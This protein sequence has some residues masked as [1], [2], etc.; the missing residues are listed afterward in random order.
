MNIPIPAT[1][2]R[3][4]SSNGL[5]ITRDAGGRIAT[6]TMAP[7]KTVTYTYDNRDNLT[8]VA[9]W[10]GDVTT[11]AYDDAGRLIEIT[12]PNGIKTNYTYD[13]ENRVTSITEGSI[14][15]IT[16]TRDGNGQI[17]S[18]ARNLP[19]SVSQNYTYTY[20]KAGRLTS[21]SMRNYTWDLASRLTSFTEGTN[22]TTFTYDSASQISTYT[23]DS[24]GRLTNDDTHSYTWDL[25]SRLTSYTEGFDATI[26]ACFGNPG[27]KEAREV[28][29]TP[30]IA[31]GESACYIAALLGDTIGIVTAGAK[32]QHQDLRLNDNYHHQFCAAIRRELRINGLA[33]RVVSIRCVDVSSA[34]GI[35]T[36][37]ERDLSEE[38]ELLIQQGKK[39]IEENG[40][41]VLILGC[42]GMIGVAEAIQ[43]ELGVPVVDATLVSLKIAEMFISLGLTHSTL[44]YPFKN[45]R[46]DECPIIYP[47][48]LKGYHGYRF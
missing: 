34:G 5:T 23:Y 28:V 22:T 32:I 36:I 21:D 31:L 6:V 16:L 44:A 1:N 8:E 19:L 33:N 25:A 17:T 12:R 10:L 2:G 37:S 9:D 14:S 29:R 38:T 39:A 26:V 35:E 4:T 27:V 24:M 40:A 47:S 13:G 46:A 45:I 48:G 18:A 43:N 3:I 11:F 30:V 15:N 20:D 41:D 7:G 42:A